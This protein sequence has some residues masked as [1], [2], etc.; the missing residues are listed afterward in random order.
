MVRLKNILKLCHAEIAECQASS[1]VGPYIAAVPIQFPY[2]KRNSLY[3]FINIE[4]ECF[5]VIQLYRLICIGNSLYKHADTTVLQYSRY[6]CTLYSDSDILGGG[7]IVIYIT[8]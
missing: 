2:S 7:R 1:Q 5:S 4:K 8:L 6:K 3:K